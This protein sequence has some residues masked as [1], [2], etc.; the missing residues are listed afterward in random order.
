MG[1]ACQSLIDE[2]DLQSIGSILLGGELK[3]ERRCSM[4]ERLARYHPLVLAPCYRRAREKGN[5]TR[6]LQGTARRL[7]RHPHTLKPCGIYVARKVIV[8]IERA[9]ACHANRKPQKLQTSVELRQ[10]HTG[11]SLLNGQR[12]SFQV[13]N[14][15]SPIAK[16]KIPEHVARKHVGK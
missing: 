1:L 14:R 4:Q 5:G 3:P 8:M 13:Q 9:T 11:M 6:S 16:S 10:L 2:C 12:S 15:A 7:R